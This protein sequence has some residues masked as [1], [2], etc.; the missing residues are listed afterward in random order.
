M[1]ESAYGLFPV[2][3]V[4]FPS[5]RSLFVTP[6]QFSPL[7]TFVIGLGGNI[8]PRLV[9][10]RAAVSRLNGLDTIRFLAVS[11]VYE[12]KPWGMADQP[13]FL[14][15]AAL[16]ES[17]LAP[18]DL[19]EA[20]LD[21]ERQLG[22]DRSKEARHWGPRSIDLDVLFAPGLVMDDP[23]LTIPHPRLRE[24]DFALRPLLDLLPDAADPRDA[25]PYARVLQTLGASS[26]RLF[27][28]PEALTGGR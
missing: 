23:R 10:L 16:A 20:L 21:I 26:L 9:A 5:P 6:A 27:A 12:S 25:T 2:S 4:S 1:R 13:D 14:N 19:L 28:P 24:R 8:E 15:A 3:F 18:L 22:R 17:H 11:P 7:P